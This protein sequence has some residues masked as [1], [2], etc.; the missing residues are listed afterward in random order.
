MASV[1]QAKYDFSSK[2]NGMLSIRSGDQ[3]TVKNRTSDD[4]WTVE[5]R[6]GE[7]GLVPVS[8]LEAVQVH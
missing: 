8:Y 7:I 3:F 5:N 1:Y 6:D 4:W 2:T